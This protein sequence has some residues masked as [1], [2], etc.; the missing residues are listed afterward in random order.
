MKSRRLVIEELNERANRLA[1]Y[2]RSRGV[3]EDSLVPI[4]VE[5]SLEMMI[6]ILGI[7]KAGAAYVPMEP[8]FPEER[9][10]FIL[11]DTEAR[12]V[13]S[14]TQSSYTLPAIDGIEIIEIDD[15]FS[16]V[17]I[18]PVSNVADGSL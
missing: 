17:S 12:M 3:K 4:C 8:D 2:L 18:Q 11:E 9:K 16:P 7:L 5:R 13:V 15:H 6:G 14:S 10:A 1:H